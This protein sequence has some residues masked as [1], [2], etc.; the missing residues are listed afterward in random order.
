MEHLDSAD[1]FV[2]SDNSNR[3]KDKLYMLLDD[4]YN[5][6]IAVSNSPDKVYKMANDLADRYVYDKDQKMFY[7]DVDD[8]FSDRSNEFYSGQKNLEHTWRID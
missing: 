8:G 5:S 1:E 3:S 2:R 6:M 4:N 7:H